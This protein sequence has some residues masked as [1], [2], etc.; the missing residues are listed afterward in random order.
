M[1]NFAITSK[2]SKKTRSMLFFLKPCCNPAATAHPSKKLYFDFGYRQTVVCVQ[3][4]GCLR[5]CK[6]L[7]AY[8]RTVLTPTLSTSYPYAKYQIPLP[9]LTVSNQWR[10]LI[11]R[12]L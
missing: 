3:A 1:L 11:V 8:R 10:P 9:F 5:I 6:R 4:N 2:K 12:E 7:F